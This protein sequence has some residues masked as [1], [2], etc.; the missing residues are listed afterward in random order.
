[1][2][3]GKAG[4]GGGDM[5]RESTV[6]NVAADVSAEVKRG[7]H[8]QARRRRRSPQHN[9]CPRER[10]F[11]GASQIHLSRRRQQE[12]EGGLRGYLHSTELDLPRNYFC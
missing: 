10:A 2:Q 8:S 1:V 7:G 3:R 6:A 5:K 9:V 11:G 12:G 4:R